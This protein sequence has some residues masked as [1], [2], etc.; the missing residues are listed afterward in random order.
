MAHYKGEPSIHQIER[1]DGHI[2]ETDVSRYF[3]SYE[4][5]PEYERE[6]MLKAK[7][8]VLDV[9]VGRKALSLAPGARTRCCRD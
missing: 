9:G 5:W 4:E 8:R 2:S 6:A 3:S 1:D 7:G